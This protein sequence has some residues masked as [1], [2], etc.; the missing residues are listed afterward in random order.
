MIEYLDG[1]RGT[2]VYIKAS[3]TGDEPED[4]IEYH[5]TQPHFP[6]DSTAEQWFEES[7]FES[8]RA[9]GYHAAAAT[10]TPSDLWRPWTPES[11]SV[12]PLF[13]GLENYWYPMNP[14]LRTGA[15]KLTERLAELLQIIEANPGLH[16]LGAQL[17]PN[18]GI[19][20]KE[21]SNPVEEFYFCLSVI[22]LVED[23]YFEFELDRVE[24]FHDPRIGG[25]RCLFRT[26][27]NVPAIASAWAA[28]RAT[29]REDFQRFWIARIS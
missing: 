6:H 22:Q 25:W 19:S 9:L 21:E 28:Q 29:F 14:N 20:P 7:Q 10:L 5:A 16:E 17:F 1:S 8:Y 18:S 11:F 26:W 27:K 2:L 15:T 4:V 12:E 13:T 23:V 3:M 24:W